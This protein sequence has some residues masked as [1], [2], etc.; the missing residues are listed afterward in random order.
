ML[1]CCCVFDDL[2]NEISLDNLLSL[3]CKVMSQTIFD[4][5]E[6]I[7]IALDA[8]M[9]RQRRPQDIGLGDFRQKEVEVKKL[10]TVKTPYRY[11]L[12]N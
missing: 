6:R 12:N 9:P 2:G 1:R 8:Q 3:R 7:L 4:E 5:T 11:T 10:C